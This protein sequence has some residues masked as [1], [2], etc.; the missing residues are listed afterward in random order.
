MTIACTAIT[1]SPISVVSAPTHARACRRGGALPRTTMGWQ[2]PAVDNPTY[3]P[4]PL[5]D[6]A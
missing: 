1:I 6:A 2:R 5:G 3:P 4:S